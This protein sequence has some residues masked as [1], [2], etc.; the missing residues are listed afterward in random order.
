MAYTSN[1]EFD[2]ETRVQ[3]TNEVPTLRSFQQMHHSL[4]SSDTWKWLIGDETVTYELPVGG[5]YVKDADGNLNELYADPVKIVN[6][7]KATKYGPK[8]SQ[9]WNP[10]KGV[11]EEHIPHYHKKEINGTWVVEQDLFLHEV[12][13]YLSTIYPDHPDWLNLLTR[14]EIIDAFNNAAA[15]V[16][17]KPNNEFFKLVADSIEFE[18]PDVEEFK[19]NLRNLTSN[20]ARRK[21]YGSTLGYRMVGHDAYENVMVFPIGKNLTLEAQYRE[22]REELKKKNELDIKQYIIDT[23]DERYQTLFRRIDWLGNS[24]DI[25]FVTLNGF[26]LSTLVV[27]GFEDFAFEFVSSKDNEYSLDKYRLYKDSVYSYYTFSDGTNNVVGSISGVKPF[28]VLQ[29]SY[30]T[31]DKTKIVKY[32]SSDDKL[33]GIQC[34]MK[35]EPKYFTLYKYKSF[36]DYKEI[37]DRFKLNEEFDGFKNCYDSSNIVVP[38]TEYFFNSYLSHLFK[39]ASKKSIEY[40]ALRDEV[41]YIYNPFI[42]NTIMLPSE[43]MISLYE[44]KTDWKDLKVIPKKELSLKKSGV[45]V[46]DRISFR[47]MSYALD[48][49]VYEIIGTSYGQVEINFLGTRKPEDYNSVNNFIKPWSQ[50]DDTIV[51]NENI[52]IV[53]RNKKN[54]LI[55]LEGSLRCFWSEKKENFNT[56][57]YFSKALF[58]IRAIPDEKSDALFNLLYGNDA[59]KLE[60]E[61]EE[62][63]KKYQIELDKARNFIKSALN[64]NLHGKPLE[65]YEELSIKESLTEEEETKLAAAIKTLETH[66]YSFWSDYKEIQQKISEEK[67]DLSKV[68]ENITQLKKNRDLLLDG[69]ILTIGYDSIVESIFTMGEGDVFNKLPFFLE[70]GFVSKLSFGNIS[71]MPVVPGLPNVKPLKVVYKDGKTHIM[72]TTIGENPHFLRDKQYYQLESNMLD[73]DRKEAFKSSS[74]IRV[75]NEKTFEIPIQVYIDKQVGKTTN[76]MQFL[77]DDAK[78]KFESIIVGSKVSGPGISSDTYVTSLGS[79]SLTISS[80]LSTGGYLIYKFE[81]PVTTAPADIKNDPFNYKKIMN[82]YGLYN[83]VSFFDHGVYGKPEWPNISSVV[84]DGDLRDKQ[85]LN[86]QTFRQVVKYLYQNKLDKNNQKVLIPSIGKYTRDVFVD[87]KADKLISVKNH[88]GNKDNLMNVEWLDYIQN[89]MELA[90]AK[91]NINVGANIVLNADTSGY[92]SLLKEAVYTDPNLKVLFQT[93]NWSSNTIPAYAQLGTGGSGM[94]DFFKLV[95]SI[96]YPNVYGA[97]FYDKT[98]EPEMGAGGEGNIADWRTEGLR[99]LVKRSTYSASESGLDITNKYTTYENIDEPIFEIPLNEYNINLKTLQKDKTFSLIDVLFYEQGFKNLTKKNELKILKDK[100]L[101][102]NLLNVYASVSSMEAALS[103]SLSYYYF[104]DGT[105]SK[106][107]KGDFHF[108]QKTNN[109][110]KERWKQYK[111]INGGVVGA[112]IFY[113][114]KS[115]NQV[116]GLGFLADTTRKKFSGNYWNKILTDEKLQDEAITE[117]IKLK[118]YYYSNVQNTSE[119]VKMRDK[120]YKVNTKEE[121]EEYKKS[122]DEKKYKEAFE[123]N[124][125]LFTYIKG[126]FDIDESGKDSHDLFGLKDFDTIGL[127]WNGEDVEYVRVNKNYT[128]CTMDRIVPLPLLIRNEI[129]LFYGYSIHNMISIYDKK[130]IEEKESSDWHAIN[131]DL[132]EFYMDLSNSILKYVTQLLNTIKLPRKYIAEGSYDINFYLDPQFVAEGYDYK[133][134]TNPNECHKKIKYNVSQSAIKYD[135]KHDVFYT[136]AHTYDTKTNSFSEDI[137]KI[138]VNFEEQKY[139]T[140]LKLLSG[141]YRVDDTQYEG[142]TKITKQASISA[143]TG[144]AFSASDLSPLDRFIEA[145]EIDLRSLYIPSLE[146]KIFQGTKNL[147]GEIYGVTKDGNLYVGGKR[148]RPLSRMYDSS[149]IDTLTSIVPATV[150]DKV[151]AIPEYEN[152]LTFIEKGFSEPQYVNVSIKKSLNPQ[153]SRTDEPIFRYY[154]NLLVFEG[155]I[156]LK[157][158][159]AVQAPNEDIATFQNVLGSLNPGDTIVGVAALSGGG[160][161]THTLISNIE[162]K[163]RFMA[164]KNNDVTVI[165]GSGKVW[166]AKNVN[167]ESQKN[168]DFV[169]T[170]VNIG[171]GEVLETIW[172]DERKCFIATLGLKKYTDKS[173]KYDFWKSTIVRTL[174]NPEIE[175]FNT[176]IKFKD[177]TNGTGP[178]KFIKREDQVFIPEGK[179]FLANDV[180]ATDY[181]K[182][183]ALINPN[184][185]AIILYKEADPGPYHLDPN[186]TLDD[187]ATQQYGLAYDKVTKKVRIV[188]EGYY[189]PRDIDETKESLFQKLY[190]DKDVDIAL[191]QE[192][193]FVKSHNYKV[194]ENGAYTR[195]KTKSKHWKVSQI[196]DILDYTLLHLKTMTVDGSNSA[197]LYVQNAFHN[198]IEW[199]FKDDVIMGAEQQPPGV[200]PGSDDWVVTFRAGALHDKYTYKQVKTYRDTVKKAADGLKSFDEFKKTIKF[201]TTNGEVKKFKIDGVDYDLTCENYVSLQEAIIKAV[202]ETQLPLNKELQIAAAENYIIEATTK[203]Y[204][205]QSRAKANFINFH[206]MYYQYLWLA[207]TKLIGEY[208]SSNFG[209]SGIVNITAANRKLFF[210][211]ATGDIISINKDK[212]YK[213]SDMQETTNWNVSTMPICSYVKGSYADKMAAFNTVEL[214]DKTKIPVSAR[215]FNVYMYRVTTDMWVAPDGTH[216]FFGG[217]TYPW[218]DISEAIKT[219]DG[220]PEDILKESW[221]KDNMS[222]WM[223]SA[224][225]T[226]KSPFIM[227]SNDGGSTFIILPLKAYVDKKLFDNDD[228]EISSF[229]MNGDSV[230]GY[231]KNQKTGGFEASQVVINFDHLGDVDVAATKYKQ[232]SIA[233]NGKIHTI[234]TDEGYITWSDSDVGYGVDIDASEMAGTKTFNFDYTG[235]NVVTIPDNLTVKRVESNYFTLDKSISSGVMNSGKVRVLMSVSTSID[236][237]DPAYYLTKDTQKIYEY[238]YKQTGYLKVPTIREVYSADIANR[239]YSPNYFTLSRYGYPTVEDDQNATHNYYEYETVDNGIG[240]VKSLK[241]ASNNEIKLCSEDG[242]FLLFE[243]R[244]LYTFEDLIRNSMS[245]T[246]AKTA[247]KNKLSVREATLDVLKM[248]EDKDFSNLLKDPTLEKFNTQELYGIIK[249]NELLKSLVEKNMLYQVE[250]NSKILDNPN[251]D[252]S[253]FIVANEGSYLSSDNNF[254]N[255]KQRFSIEFTGYEVSKNKVFAIYDKKYQC[256]LLKE[257][258]FITGN[259][260]IPYTFYNNGEGITIIPNPIIQYIKDSY[261]MTGDGYLASGIYYNPK[262]YGGL[263]NNYSIE[264]NTPWDRDPYAFEKDL[265]KNSLG[266]YVYLTDEF[267]NRIK[268]YNATRIATENETVS[269]N[270]FFYDGENTITYGDKTVKFYKLAEIEITQ[271]HSSNTV[272]EW[273]T[274]LLRFFKNCKNLT[275]IQFQDKYKDGIYNSKGEKVFNAKQSESFLYIKDQNTKYETTEDLYAYMKVRVDSVWK[276]VSIKFTYDK[277]E[278]PKLELSENTFD[279]IIYHKRQKDGKDDY[280]VITKVPEGEGRII[281]T[282]K[283]IFHHEEKGVFSSESSGVKITKTFDGTDTVISIEVTALPT[284]FSP[285]VIQYNKKD[286]HRLPIFYIEHP[287]YSYHSK[288][289]IGDSLFNKNTNVKLLEPTALTIEPIAYNEVKQLKDV[290]KGDIITGLYG[291]CISRAPKYRSFSDLIYYN[292][293][294]IPKG[295]SKKEGELVNVNISE[296]ADNKMQFKLKNPLGFKKYDDGNEHYFRFKL[297]TISHQNIAAVHM[298]DDKY[299]KEIDTQDILTFPPDRV[300]FNPKGSPK[301][302]IKVGNTIYNEESNYAYYN[303]DFVND[304]GNKI[305][306]CDETGHYIGYDVFGK[307]F[308]LDKKNDGNCSKSVYPGFDERY[309]SPKPVNPTCKGWYKE[310][311]WT[312]NKDVNPLWQVISIKPKIENKVWVQ[313]V[314]LNRYVKEENTQTLS[315]NILHPYVNIGNITSISAKDDV[316]SYDHDSDKF[317]LKD[318]II[319]LLL[320]EGSSYFKENSEVTMYGLHFETLNFKK[321]YSGEEV[322]N[323]IVPKLN[324]T[325]QA[326]YTVNTTRDFST[327]VQEDRSIVKVTELGL[328]DRNHK[329]IAYANFPPVEYRTDKQHAAFTCVI[330]YG[331]MVEN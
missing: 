134:Y 302:P 75:Y 240:K 143:I 88:F 182:E 271:V 275:D 202:S 39:L 249:S 60:K 324:A 277:V 108:A 215:S 166:E 305:Y 83:K 276:N 94:R 85:I 212:L 281:K 207:L 49:V 101:S 150:K 32:T 12:Y 189:L 188:K 243:N 33:F 265:L 58:N 109:P 165:D 266:E 36:E 124:L 225:K 173:F 24:R 66:A 198:F 44:N 128:L 280:A 8:I 205:K 86:P 107:K 181:V 116:I 22:K 35:N 250:E 300:W 238:E 328:F 245:I 263:R 91:E 57:V 155:L 213:V 19:L 159:T 99:K 26:N 34:S 178:V 237:D 251:F 257:R 80:S 214:E 235:S 315:T 317:N 3:I 224:D 185:I 113:F 125:I 194:N 255:A 142:D 100:E 10:K 285:V 264:N 29:S 167:F 331:N 284:K 170:D 330:Y 239:I 114:S 76:E 322:V 130:K 139:F 162:S 115:F 316:L 229:E 253:E 38:G 233:P 132:S 123:N 148:V 11:Y 290:K 242:R 122:Y 293:V 5:K 141:A 154:K 77:T 14:N 62:T 97:T 292:G 169:Q 200:T 41:E 117:I 1:S 102:T 228:Y 93:L 43:K 15:M 267:G 204:V 120:L 256:F 70:K 160:Y 195:E 272:T 31:E 260:V 309:V 221:M 9:K 84:F 217:Y 301:P 54:E 6:G 286:F 119:V 56:A 40:T 307:E 327:S 310:N 319:R 314:T 64:E 152:G 163:A 187:K 42:K 223:N 69:R 7:K 17:Y 149:I 37:F 304:S 294:I 218:K 226:G 299:Y 208:F 199:A 171:E 48:V 81:C 103:D 164:V 209:T 172:D 230:V 63:I 106:D 90:L 261:K 210:R 258:R 278:L 138:V 28:N 16:D 2:L 303:E 144:E 45:S 241:N 306:L 78:K 279:P 222:N 46:G 118:A 27:P 23:F 269:Y 140:N 325:L 216:M 50:V 318:G 175:L 136:Y 321:L 273:K 311:M 79:N 72:A 135:E 179:T 13:R 274:I 145:E 129:N 127:L 184:D 59:Y 197:Y 55:E 156:D 180:V 296:I 47:D 104:A 186:E 326:S 110:G 283:F 30:V 196:P 190:S 112:P 246:S 248:V 211:L 146:S 287:I 329:L 68:R 65:I 323:A 87:I 131:K 183:Q 157:H 98:V 219:N 61:I 92:A 151:V 53:I 236:I 51:S 82:E 133:C 161:N 25:S 191:T 298:N 288:L 4:Q 176:N 220:K 206:E 270:D 177:F 308:R 20:A 297:L 96:Y 18:D 227:Y 231:V 234:E 71:V 252:V 153:Y 158:S 312:P 95:S 121:F 247:G 291:Y 203:N 174:T 268:T 201:Y 282:Y 147:T 259:L 244:N 67:E 289:Y 105:N 295:T 111:V 89:N 73:R 254:E 262:G 52:A 313:S 74:T 192:Y 126:H 168:V 193:M 232:V 21:F 320:S 137:K